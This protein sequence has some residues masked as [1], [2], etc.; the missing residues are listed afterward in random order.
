MSG[1]TISTNK[2]EEALGMSI[3]Y[4]VSV[5]VFPRSF[6]LKG[7]SGEDC[8]CLRLCAKLCYCNATVLDTA[9]DTNNEYSIYEIVNALYEA[10]LEEY[11]SRGSIPC[12]NVA[13]FF[14]R[15]ATIRSKKE[16]LSCGKC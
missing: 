12:T 11:F 7:R 5:Y 13:L 9:L 2:V 14:E 4:Y 8:V 1:F 10:Y 15:F 16:E 6:L 3:P